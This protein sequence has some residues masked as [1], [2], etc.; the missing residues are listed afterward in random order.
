MIRKII[1]FIIL[2]L[3]IFAAYVLFLRKD[4]TLTQEYV[5][6][7]Y[8]EPTS[9]FINWK[10]AELHYTESGTGF[11]ILM[12]HGFGGSHK[13]FLPLDSLFNTN[14]RVIR[15]DLPGFAL[16]QFPYAE[17]DTTNYLAAYNE[18]FNFL[19][20]T[21]HLDSF[22]VMGNSLG[23]LMAWNL[24]LQHPDKVKKLVLLNSAGYDMREVMKT[25]NADRFRNPLLKT[26]LKKGIPKFM[27]ANGISRIF[28]DGSTLT[29]AKIQRVSDFW[30]K[31]G[32]LK[33]ILSMASSN[34][35]ID[36]EKIKNIQ[37]PTLIIW[38]K[39]DVIVDVK[40]ADRFHQDIKNSKVQVYNNCGHVPMLEM[41]NSVYND[42]QRFFNE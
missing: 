35:I 11:P 20:D 28:Y 3:I 32:N 17:T 29:D 38:G 13:D 39:N 42:V 24:T 12:I 36:Q 41:T 30:N 27:I 4:L 6:Q 7:K 22:Y 34:Q 14:H 31:A 19:I 8:A 23:G 21:L 33:H 2:L 40:Y 15:V 26:A 10:G 9:K 16:S 5:K 18:Y 37:I 1:L 25:A